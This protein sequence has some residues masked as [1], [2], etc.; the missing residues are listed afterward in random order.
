MDPFMGSQGAILTEA[1]STLEALIRF[2]PRVGP[3]MGNKMAAVVEA[4]AAVRA[5]I[6]FSIYMD[7]SME[8]KRDVPLE[9][10]PISHAFFLRLFRINTGVFTNIRFLS[11]YFSKWETHSFFSL[12]SLD[13]E[14]MEICVLRSRDL[15]VTI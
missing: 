9:T 10:F 1:L 5:L 11:N 15:Q 7:A 12:I 3:L 6:G 13:Q 14:K 4:V 8:S 2:L